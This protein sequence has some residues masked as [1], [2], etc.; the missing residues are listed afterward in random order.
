MKKPALKWTVRL[1]ATAEKDFLD[2]LDWT[3]SQ[4]GA[5]QHRLYAGMLIDA[6]TALQEGPAAIGVKARPELGKDIY[7]LPIAR[8]GRRGRH[9]IVFR[10]A[11]IADKLYID[12]LRILHDSMD[13]T[14]HIPKDR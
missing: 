8:K 9:F 13:L 7:A 10:A 3:A 11:E 1:A 2:I 6:I 5:R 14:R 4:F 12:I